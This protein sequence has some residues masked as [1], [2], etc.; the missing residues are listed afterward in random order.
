MKVHS[1]DGCE[2]CNKDGPREE[3]HIMVGLGRMAPFNKRVLWHATSDHIQWRCEDF[4]ES[5]RQAEET[6]SLD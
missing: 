1:F 5:S 4:C 2:A 3:D 6:P